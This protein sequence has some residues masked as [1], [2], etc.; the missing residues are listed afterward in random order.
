MPD[1]DVRMESGPEFLA[2]TGAESGGNGWQP[3]RFRLKR[4]DEIR[5]STARNY[6]IKGLLPRSGLAVIWGPPKCGKSFLAFDMAMHVAICRDYRGRRVQRGAVVYCALEGGGGF[7]ARVEAWRQGKLGDIDPRQV[8]FSLLDVPLD[9]IAE[10]GALVASIRAQVPT[11]TL[12]FIDTLNKALVGD[13]NSSADMGRLVKASDAIIAAFDCLVVLVHH[14]GIA[15]TRPRGHT[16]LS[17]AD[18]AQIAV[19]K[20][21]DG[22]ITVTTEHMKDAEP[23]PPFAC[24]LERI[25]LGRDDDGDPITSCI[26]VPEALP[27]GAQGRKLSGTT[28]LAYDTLLVTLQGG[29]RACPLVVWRERFYDAHPAAKADTK[30]KAFVRSTL[31]LQ[32]LQIIRVSGE[33][34]TLSGQGGHRRTN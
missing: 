6:H 25:E 29:H 15:G 22:V 9:L 19:S 30:Q 33:E 12:V 17:G 21:R 3:P 8:L 26:V 10:C 4:F 20:D 14:C 18:D 1:D 2:R 16:S 28:K 27:D 23:G 13:E 32:E 5:V 7:P 34:V 31:K 11:P 24:R